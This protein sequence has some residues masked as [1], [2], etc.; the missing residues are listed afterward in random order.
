MPLTYTVVAGGCNWTRG[1]LCETSKIETSNTFTFPFIPLHLLVIQPAIQFSAFFIHPAASEWVTA[2]MDD[3]LWTGKLHYSFTS[4]SSVSFPLNVAGH[5]N[6]TRVGFSLDSPLLRFT[7]RGLY[8]WSIGN[9]FHRRST[10]AATSPPILAKPREECLCRK[11]FVKF[12]TVPVRWAA[13]TTDQ[14]H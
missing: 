5:P 10:S 1:W 11:T 8:S 14:L 3:V 12:P 7:V 2:E 6:E 4:S 13:G 9:P